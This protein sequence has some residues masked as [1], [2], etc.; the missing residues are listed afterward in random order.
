MP[1]KILSLLALSCISTFSLAAIDSPP[2]CPD[3][4][5]I[6]LEGLSNILY[7][8]HKLTGKKYFAY[9]QSEYDTPQTWLFGISNIDADTKNLARQKANDLLQSISGTPSAS[10]VSTT[11]FTVWVCHYQIE[12]GYFADAVSMPNMTENAVPKLSVLFESHP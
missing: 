9:E 4:H 3:V 12:D 7:L 8:E 6:Q 2:Q 1:A 5:L 10:S 11:K